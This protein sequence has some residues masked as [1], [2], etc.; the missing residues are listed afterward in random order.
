MATKK[1]AIA[2]ARWDVNRLISASG[3]IDALIAA[4]AELGF[5]ALSYPTI[6]SW[7]QRRSIPSDRL[8]EVLVTVAKLRGGLDVWEYIK[9]EE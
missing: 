4:H 5:E 7:R 9:Q 8:A 6:A 2:V 3:G 1:T